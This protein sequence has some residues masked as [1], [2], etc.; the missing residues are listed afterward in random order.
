MGYIEILASFS[1]WTLNSPSTAIIPY[2]NSLDPDQTPSNSASHP[3]PSCLQCPYTLFQALCSCCSLLDSKHL[4]LWVYGKWSS[5]VTRLTCGGI[6][7][8]VGVLIIFS[9]RTLHFNLHWDVKPHNSV[10]QKHLL[11]ISGRSGLDLLPRR[12]KYSKI[13]SHG[14][15]EFKDKHYCKKQFWIIIFL[16]LENI[17]R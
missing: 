8:L 11:K 7:H 16:K 10:N 6:N 5:S 15:P 12:N 2:A 3:D 14:F 9:D 13:V 1:V 17:E 4:M